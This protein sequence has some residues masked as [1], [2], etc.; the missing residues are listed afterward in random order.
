MLIAGAWLIGL[1]AAAIGGRFPFWVPAIYAVVSVITYVTYA[2]DKSRAGTDAR[3]VPERTLHFLA[4]VG[5]WPGALVAQRRFRHKT[6]KLRFQVIFWLIVLTH[7][8]AAVWW[9]YAH[10]LSNSSV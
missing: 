5:G 8:A 6:L 9:C 1:S 7:F 3:R 10:L 2:A 4:L